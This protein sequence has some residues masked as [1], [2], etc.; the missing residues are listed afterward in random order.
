MA[1]PLYDALFGRHSGQAT[2][3]LQMQD[4][5]VLTHGQ[6]VQQAA[7]YAHVLNE[8]GLRPGDRV[9][10]QIEKSPQSL[11]IYAA[12]VQAGL[13]FL[14]LNTAYTAHE[15]AYFVEDSGARVVICDPKSRESLAPIALAT[16]AQLETLDAAGEGS[17][18]QK[19][20]PQPRQFATVPREAEDL[21]AFLYTSGTT[22]R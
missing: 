12:C 2:V 4:G 1:N 3:F 9:A 8:F 22:G 5:T 15:L 10:V 7:Q 21:A 19:A 14:P 13:I 6:F 16:G 11:A 20:A 18:A 17:F